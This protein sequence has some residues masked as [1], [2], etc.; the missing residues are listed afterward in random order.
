MKKDEEENDVVIKINAYNLKHNTTSD[1]ILTKKGKTKT[2]EISI[3]V[4]PSN[5]EEIKEIKLSKEVS[6]RIVDLLKKNRLINHSDDIQILIFGGNLNTFKGY[7]NVVKQY[8]YR[9]IDKREKREPQFRLYTTSAEE[10]E[11]VRYN[12][13]ICRTAEFSWQSVIKKC[14]TEYGIV[15]KLNKEL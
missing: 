7:E 5:I 3:I 2:H 13:N 11:K 9:N 15:F 8:P 1:F 12:L 4:I 10:Q 6:Q 14:G